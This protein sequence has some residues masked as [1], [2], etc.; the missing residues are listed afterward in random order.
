MIT[1]NL[2]YQLRYCCAPTEARGAFSQ[3]TRAAGDFLMLATFASLHNAADRLVYLIERRL[4]PV[5]ALKR[6][7]TYIC[8][9]INGCHMIGGAYTQM[10]A[11]DAQTC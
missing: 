1:V 2:R 11:S 6:S 9:K 10:S 7:E 4:L 8:T 3:Q 5:S